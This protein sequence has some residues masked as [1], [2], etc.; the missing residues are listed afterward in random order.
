MLTAYTLD[1]ATLS[2][3]LLIARLILGLAMAAHGAQK[4]FGWFGGY[5]LAG[6]AGFF[7][8]LGFRPGRLFAS[9]AALAEFGSGLLMALGL[10]GP[11]G[12]ALMI[13]VMVVAMI[14]AHAKNGFFAM[15]NGIE[16]PLLYAAGAL[17]LAFTGPGA[18]SLD[19]LLGLGFLSTP[20]IVVPV[21]GVAVAGA[22][23]SLAVRHPAAT[24]AVAAD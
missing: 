6:T 5:G 21:L 4:L 18:F 11:I 12:P 2:G 17:A 3:G 1:V 23:G 15:S 20:T 10:L 9:A 7:E 13:S 16:L 19:A 24:P 22:L 14:T 8:T